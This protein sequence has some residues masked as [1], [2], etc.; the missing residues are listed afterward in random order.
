MPGPPRPLASR[1]LSELLRSELSDS[2]TVARLATA[3]GLSARSLHRLALRDFGTSPMD[4][5]RSARLT[6]AR[7]ELATPRPNASVT[8]VALDCGFTHLSRFSQ[9]YARTFGERPSET[10]Q[11]ARRDL[12]SPARQTAL[13]AAS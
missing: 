4:L 9:E 7:A 8:R 5:L 3:L 10:L 6:Q 12:A 13:P 11:R 2:W 1:R